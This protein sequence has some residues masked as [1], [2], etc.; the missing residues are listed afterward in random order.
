MRLLEDGEE[1]EGRGKR[2]KGLETE[3]TRSMARRYEG[4]VR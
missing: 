1:M 2:D 4:R 3:I